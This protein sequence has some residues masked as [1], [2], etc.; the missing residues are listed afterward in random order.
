M[1]L[2]HI[3]CTLRDGGY[4]N[5]WDFPR[6][7]IVEYLNAM[8]AL[9][10]N[11]VEIGFRSFDVHGFKGACAYSTDDFIRGL[12]IPSRLKIG[13]MMN[14]AEL[15]K[16]PSGAVAAA[17]A[18]FVQADESPVTLVRFACHLHE[19]EATLPACAWLKGMG[20]KVGINLMQIADR[21]EA[22]IEK[23]G[24]LASTYPLDVMYFADS[25]GCMNPE[26]TV[27]IV[28]ILRR[29]WKGALGVHTHDNM[30]QAV[31][32]T[33]Q[34]IASGV[35]WIDSTVTGM[36]RGP[37]NAQTE[38]LVLELQRITGRQANLAPLLILI[39][40]HFGA[41][42]ARYGWG[43]NA[44]YYLAGQYGIHPTYIQE[45]LNDPRYGEVEILSVIEHLRA[46]GGKKYNP[47]T[48]DA[49]R[50]MYGG[51]AEGTWAPASAIQGREVL[52]VGSGPG[53]VAH[54]DAIERYIRKHAPYVIALN[55]Q[56]SISF[57]LIDIRA[58][59]HPFRLFADCS[60]YKTLP[61]PLV[62]PASRLPTW[63]RGEL[64]SVNQL[65]FGLA[66]QPGEFQFGEASAT[67]P[68]S[69][70]IAY[71]LAIATSGLAARILMAGFDGYSLEDP[72]AVEMEELIATYQRHPQSLP[73]LAI[74]PTR[75]NLPVTS[76][77]A[78]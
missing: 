59:C 37:G 45:M 42:Q 52:I 67:A 40:M 46:V 43:K 75:F 13:V 64:E 19:I 54:R 31:A 24:Q 72:R 49:G 38:Y 33:V 1:E 48:L 61:Q 34:A 65:D 2:M 36:G 41:M 58:A 18:M 7:V 60:I 47:V 77:Y 8:D 70:V 14:A 4:Y 76:V 17:Q 53:I 9:G 23:I 78:L 55:T 27:S 5:N 68:S 21:T 73:L 56:C 50:Q 74:T 29:H 26:Q 51:M 10:V 20:Y 32:N 22:E 44:Y 28:N 71:A 25:F 6:E 12:P 63:V 16:H 30:G 69:L 66:V 39:R 62:V 3:D 57:E 35:T 11:Y 15:Q